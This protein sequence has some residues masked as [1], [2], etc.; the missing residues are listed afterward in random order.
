MSATAASPKASASAMIGTA[1][2][3]FMLAMARNS[4]GATQPPIAI[5]MTRKP[6]A[7]ARM[8]A[9]L[10]GDSAPAGGDAR[11][12]R[13]DHEP[14]HVVDDGGADDDPSFRRAE[15]REV[16]EHSGG[17]ADRGG[18]QR[19]ADEDGGGAEGRRVAH[20][21][22]NVRP[23]EVAGQEGQ[24]HAD[25]RDRHRRP[26]HLPHLPEVGLEPDFEQQHED[27]QFGENRDDVDRRAGGGDDPQ[28]ARAE[29]HPGEQLT[30]DGGLADAFGNLPEKLGGHENGSE[31]EEEAG[32]AVSIS[33]TRGRQ[34][35]GNGPDGWHHDIKALRRRWAG[36]G[37]CG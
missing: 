8:R 24:H 37:R 14:E 21:V 2:E 4:R 32:D 26:A 13:Q 36:S 25:R 23:E 31:G 16:G 33:P 10:N 19:C 29:D 18:G 6:T 17:D 28:R 27:A 3:T 20:A 11:H 35:G 34:H 5:A 30:E 7:T 1:Y 15:I 12:D 22:G 9:T